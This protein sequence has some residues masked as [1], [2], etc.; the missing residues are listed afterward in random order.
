MQISAKHSLNYIKTSRKYKKNHLATGLRLDAR[1]GRLQRSPRNLAGIQGKERGGR[2]KGE[3]DGEKRKGV[4]V[5]GEERTNEWERKRRG[6]LKGTY[7]EE[8]EVREWKEREGSGGRGVCPLPPIHGVFQIFSYD[9]H[10]YSHI[11]E[12]RY[13][14]FK[15]AACS[16]HFKLDYYNSVLHTII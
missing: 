16:V 7:G 4:R 10:E 2:G 15:T 12:L 5:K 11:R 9:I 13:L 8:R 1:C 6:G 14:D 3:R